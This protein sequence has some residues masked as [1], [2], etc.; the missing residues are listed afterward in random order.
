[1]RVRA[2]VQCLQ[3]RVRAVCDSGAHAQSVCGPSA[4]AAISPCTSHTFRA[5]DWQ[6]QPTRRRPRSAFRT[7]E[8]R[9]LSAAAA[10]GAGVSTVAARQ[11]F[12]CFAAIYL[13]TIP[14]NQSP[15]LTEAA[16]QS[17]AAISGKR[18][19]GSV[20]S[21]AFPKRCYWNTITDGVY[22]NP[23]PHGIAYSGQIYNFVR[24]I[25]DPICGGAP[26]SRRTAQ[27]MRWRVAA[28]HAAVLTVL[29]GYCVCTS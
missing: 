4:H 11:L 15:E 1:M 18:Y 25:H 2:H 9:S 10:P 13:G 12:L 22:Y 21:S 14:C 26:T 17:L 19:A 23:D 3:V 28:R 29:T 16:C 27:R 20:A 6:A 8:G 7:V 5:C 24:S